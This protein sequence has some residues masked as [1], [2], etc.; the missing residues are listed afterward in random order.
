MQP[1]SGK[2]PF[3][4]YRGWRYAEDVRNLIKRQAHE[5][6]ELHDTRLTRVHLFEPT[7]SLVYIK[8][9]LDRVSGQD[10]GLSQRD[11]LRTIPPGSRA[12]ARMVHQNASHHLGSNA[13]EMRTIT[14]WD[15]LSKQPKVRLVHQGRWLQGV[16]VALSSDEAGRK[17]AKFVVH[18]PGCRIGGSL[19]SSLGCSQKLRKIR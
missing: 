18:H 9:I 14:P 19:I 2:H 11:H 3:A 5:E 12:T 13:E 15:F 16:V 10:V 1:S 6:L 7:Q 4:A 17:R 8:H